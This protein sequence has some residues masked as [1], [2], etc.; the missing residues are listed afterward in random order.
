MLRRPYRIGADDEEGKTM[1][2]LQHVGLAVGN[3]LLHRRFS[4]RMMP[5]TVATH[6]L[7][8]RCRSSEHR[9]N[10]EQNSTRIWSEGFCTSVAII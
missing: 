5:V 4:L 6:S 2:A 8:R 1:G 3:D 10:G 7:L 9:P